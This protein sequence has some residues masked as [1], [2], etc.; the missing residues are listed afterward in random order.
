MTNNL[1][2]K[3]IGFALKGFESILCDI[4]AFSTTVAEPKATFGDTLTVPYMTHTSA[5]NAFSYS[6]GYLSDQTSIVGK[7]VVLNNLLYRVANVADNAYGKLDANSLEQL[8]GG[9][10]EA[11]ARDVISAS[12]SS[13]LTEAHFPTSASITQT[14]LTSSIGLSNLVYQADTLNWTDKRSLILSPSAF[15][16]VLQNADVNKSYAFGSSEPVQE[17]KIQNVYGFSTH[18]YNGLFPVVAQPAKGIACDTSA[19][20]FGFGIHKPA[21]TSKGLVQLTTGASKGVVLSLK[22]FYNTSLAT[23]QFVLESCFGVGV[24]VSTGLVWLK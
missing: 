20:L 16:Y 6:T 10:G 24:G 3:Y 18:K 9:M 15:Q 21:D 8:F 4:S 14:N 7:D 11:L 12:F 13:V 5:S 1:D 2:L 22:T 23:T 19:I 17:G